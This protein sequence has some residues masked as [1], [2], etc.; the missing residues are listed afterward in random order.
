LHGAAFNYDG[1]CNK[2]MEQ[3]QTMRVGF[4]G[5]SFD[6]PH[7]GHL[8]VA[9][10]AAQAFALDKVLLAPT[11]WQPLKPQG[12]DASFADR[13]AMVELLCAGQPGLEASSLESPEETTGP[14]YTIDTL[15]RLRAQLQPSDEIYV[16]V[17]IDAFLD[18]ERWRDPRGLLAAA[19]WIVV[20]RPE[21]SPEQINAMPLS[22]A[23]RVR[24]HLLEDV[25]VPVS[26]TE[27]RRRLITGEDCSGWL[28]PR[29]LGYIRQHKLYGAKT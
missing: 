8:A 5:G 27:V 9:Q 20:A 10:A 13:L 24:V 16:V 4:F 11:A 1:S 29:V 18:I 6:P 22:A 17:G 15:R 7:I 3:A 12:A 28:P 23:E 21:F 14:N 19:Q 2:I 25:Q 26:A